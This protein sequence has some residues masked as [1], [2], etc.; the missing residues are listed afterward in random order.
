MSVLSPKTQFFAVTLLQENMGVN[1]LKL[2][3]KQWREHPSQL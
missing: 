3:A 1:G 2:Q